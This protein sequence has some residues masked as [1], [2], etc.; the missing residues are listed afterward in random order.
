MYKNILVPL[1]GSK[2]AEQAIPYATELC[3]GST[4]VTLFQVVHLPLNLAAP[5]VSIATP[6]P[7]PQEL[8]EEALAYLEELA[9]PLREEGVTIKTDA[10]ERDVVADAIVAYAREH[11]IDLIVMTTHGRSGLSRLVFGSVAESVVRHTPCPVLLIRV[12]NED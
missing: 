1:D 4:E 6:L 2:L 9:K 5:D 10:I 8:I 7:D 3:K 11:D 12:Q